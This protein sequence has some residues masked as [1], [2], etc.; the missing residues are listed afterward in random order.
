MSKQF[1]AVIVAVV[2]VLIGVFVF[3]GSGS[4]DSGSKNASS[5]V[6]PTEHTIGKG[7]TGVTLTEY[8]DYQCPYCEEYAATVNQVR[9]KYGD[10]IT[11]QFR[12][13]PLTN[14]HQNA[15]AAARAA[16]AAGL[17]NK[18]WE[19]H[20]AL[21]NP[22]NWQVW[23]NSSSPTQL[24]DQYAKE[25][26]LNVSQF[27][28]DYSSSKVNDLINADMAAGNKLGITGTPT[29]YID[30]KKIDVANDQ[31]SFAKLIDAEIAKKQPA[32]T[33]PQPTQ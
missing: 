12:N 21:Y 7:T 16:E 31:A 2:L 3:T 33:Q 11:F 26:G 5:K 25:I 10:Q 22:S 15:F 13:F 1:W 14:L 4:N 28:K 23:T 27:Q 20:D 9:Q 29:F 8:G 30:G 17:Q 24:F 18:Y 6:A 19:M 32:A